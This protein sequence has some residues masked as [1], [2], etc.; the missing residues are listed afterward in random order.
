MHLFG[1][2]VQRRYHKDILRLTICNTIPSVRACTVIATGQGVVDVKTR[3]PKQVP[4]V[5]KVSGQVAYVV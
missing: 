2:T 3:G 4:S 1:Q 5:L